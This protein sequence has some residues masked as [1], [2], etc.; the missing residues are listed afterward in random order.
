MLH[1][2]NILI[3]TCIMASLFTSAF[4][5]QAQSKAERVRFPRG[6]SSTVL[7]GRILGFDTKDYLIGAKAGQTM[8]LRL[9]SSNQYAYFVVY[10]I[11][12]RATD[13][14]ET[15]EWSER[16]SEAGDYMIRVFMLRAGARRKGAAASYRLNVTIQ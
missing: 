6:R 9:S 12:G 3:L 13:M 16:L 7:R 4:P 5:A 10:S 8:T 15:T 2:R 11:N 14:N 1:R